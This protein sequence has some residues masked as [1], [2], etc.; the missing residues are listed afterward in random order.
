MSAQLQ[1]RV[2]SSERFVPG[3]FKGLLK[4]HTMDPSEDKKETKAMFDLPDSSQPSGPTDSS[5]FTATETDFFPMVHQS[6]RY[7]GEV[8][9]PLVKD[10][11]S[12]SVPMQT[13]LKTQ[14]V[15]P[16]NVRRPVTFCHMS[17]HVSLNKYCSIVTHVVP[18]YQKIMLEVAEMRNLLEKAIYLP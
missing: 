14:G 13:S 10:M 4:Q 3:E 1:R 9:S 12:G 5:K 8:A 15:S 6:M 2:S 18:C 16:R 11:A 7:P 17:G